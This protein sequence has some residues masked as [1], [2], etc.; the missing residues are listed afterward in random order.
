MAHDA[1]VVAAVVAAAAAAVGDADDVEGI[2]T[3]MDS[4]ADEDVRRKG[5]CHLRTGKGGVREGGIATWR[6]ED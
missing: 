2:K 1:V 3:G 4:V 5:L 6:A